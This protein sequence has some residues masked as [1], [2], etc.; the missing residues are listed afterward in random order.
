M[1]PLNINMR[2]KECVIIGGGKIAYRKT[3]PL[4]S[5]GAMVTI[6][7]PEVCSEIENLALEGK[8]KLKKRHP[9]EDDFQSAFYVIAAT[10]NEK[11]NAEIT[12]KLEKTKL[13]LNASSVDK[14]NCHVPASFKK[15]KLLLTVSTSG[16]SPMLAKKIRD[17]WSALYDDN[18]E[19]YV[20]F[21]YEA[22][23]QIKQL[24][25]PSARK[26]YLLQEIIDEK[27]LDSIENRQFFL[28]SLKNF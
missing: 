18:F 28:I 27:Y 26:K 21:L 11:V 9:L 10:N 23:E 22:R 3:S 19:H 14:G 17:Q 5:G 2:G 25:I 8:V 20:D 12:T 7:S 15:G 13:V 16:A 6:I 24:N 4:I 1:Y